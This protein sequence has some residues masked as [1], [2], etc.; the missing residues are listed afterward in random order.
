MDLSYSH[1][2]LLGERYGG[3][4]R[5][6]FLLQGPEKTAVVMVGSVRTVSEKAK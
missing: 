4:E 5:G 2:A 6:S 3:R 1:M